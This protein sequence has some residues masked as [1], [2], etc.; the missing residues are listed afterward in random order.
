MIFEKKK[1][2]KQNKLKKKK[3]KNV[4]VSLEIGRVLPLVGNNIG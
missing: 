1:N 4:L 3:K 2:E